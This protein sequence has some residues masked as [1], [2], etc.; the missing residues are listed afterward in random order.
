MGDWKAHLSEPQVEPVTPD[1]REV[2]KLATRAAIKDTLQKTLI[3]EQQAPFVLRLDQEIEVEN[4]VDKYIDWKIGELTGASQG[5]PFGTALDTYL[6]GIGVGNSIGASMAILN[7]ADNNIA[8]SL[9]ELGL[10]TETDNKSVNLS[11]DISERQF[12]QLVLRQ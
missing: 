7:I 10:N 11:L 1:K 8:N 6:E 12:H 4:L 2:I 9:P 3:T 5:R